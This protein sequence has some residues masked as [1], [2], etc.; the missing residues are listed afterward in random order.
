MSKRN[1]DSRRKGDIAEKVFELMCVERGVEVFKPI[2]S[3][4]RIDYIIVHDGRFK[5]VQIKYISASNGK[6][7]VSFTKNQNG[8]K[9]DAKPMYK[10]YDK[11]EIDLFLV[12]CPDTQTWYNIPIELADDQN[13]I[14][15]RITSTKNN[16]IQNVNDAKDYIWSW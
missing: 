6:I 5:K 8:R 12:Y 4:S 9:V 14:I 7:S 2:N 16:Q 13:G 1:E 15:L 11:L 3:G 10:K